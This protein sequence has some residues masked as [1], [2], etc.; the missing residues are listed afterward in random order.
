[1]HA[2]APLPVSAPVKARLLETG[3]NRRRQRRRLAQGI[4]FWIDVNRNAPRMQRERFTAPLRAKVVTAAPLNQ[5]RR[6]PARDQQTKGRFEWCKDGFVTIKTA[7]KNLQCANAC[8]KSAG[9][10]QSTIQ[11]PSCL[12]PGWPNFAKHSCGVT[13]TPP[14]TATP[15]NQGQHE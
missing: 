4:G 14:F 6:Q 10:S 5:L 13:K 1:M 3:H 2:V 15:I 12:E 11:R 9:T 8:S 7:R